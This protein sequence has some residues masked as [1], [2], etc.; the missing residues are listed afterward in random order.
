M[1]QVVSGSPVFLVKRAPS[2]FG[3]KRGCT[4]LDSIKG[5]NFLVGRTGISVK[6][7]LMGKT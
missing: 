7:M 2:F 1:G 4:D 3:Q 6:E 5:F